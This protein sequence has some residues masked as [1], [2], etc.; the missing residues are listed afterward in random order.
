MDVLAVRDAVRRAAEICRE[1]DGPVLIEASTYRYYGHSLSDP[2]NEYR[3][4][5]EE[6]AWKAIDAIEN[7]KAQLVEAGVADADGVA[8]WSGA[9]ATGMLAR[10][11]GRRRPPTRHPEL[12]RLPVHRRHQR[13]RPGG[14]D[15]SNDLLTGPGLE[16]WPR[17]CDHVSRRAARGPRRGDDP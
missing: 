17:R 13:H 15:P 9:S 11:S 4:R 16:G 12:A 2:R 7:L 8:P 3:T 1:G 10:P 14:R 6:A 5:E